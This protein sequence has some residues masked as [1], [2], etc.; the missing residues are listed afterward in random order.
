MLK[1]DLGLLADS[2]NWVGVPRKILGRTLKFWLKIQHM[3][4]YNFAISGSNL[5]KLYQVTC[6][7][8]AVIRW[9]LLWGGVPQQNLGGPKSPKFGTI[10]DNYRL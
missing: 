6:C 5:T 7:E 1:I 9:V 8:A 3:C 2:P 10:S 4:A